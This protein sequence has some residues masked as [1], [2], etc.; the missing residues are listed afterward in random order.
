MSTPLTSASLSEALLLP[1]RAA[2]TGV[3]HPDVA[4][5][6]RTIAREGWRVTSIIRP[7]SANHASGRALDVAPLLFHRAGFG[8]RTGELLLRVLSQDNPAAVWLALAEDDHVHLQLLDP[9][10]DHILGLQHR[11][12]P[13]LFFSVSPESLRTAP[14]G[15]VPLK[16]LSRQKAYTMIRYSLPEGPIGD[17][18][19]SF[20]SLSDPVHV[21]P[22]DEDETAEIGDYLSYVSDDFEEGDIGDDDDETGDYDGGDAAEEGGPRKRG[23]RKTQKVVR[24]RLTAR[25]AKTGGAAVSKALTAMKKKRPASAQHLAMAAA[26]RRASQ[27]R[28]VEYEHLERLSS[29]NSSL[30]VGARLRST[31]VIRFAAD[32]RS[33]PIVEPDI[34]PFTYAAGVWTLNPVIL[35]NTRL[36]L[37]NGT[38]FPYTG[39]KVVLASSTYNRAAGQQIAISRKLGSRTLTVNARLHPGVAPTATLLN[40][41]IVAGRPRY[42]APVI[43]ADGTDTAS[44]YLVSVTGLPDN[45]TPIARLLVPG[46]SETERF[47]ALL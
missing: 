32:V 37:P 8:P 9:A 35:L 24:A 26:A 5:A 27:T 28:W 33:V 23:R 46:D 44:Q 30:G 16:P 36:G 2:T 14:L 31:E 47:L 43:E 15:S 20:P 39:L 45:Y 41:G 21:V 22:S 25:A 4:R 1:P 38:L 34:L 18:D 11:G 29:I 40:G 7:G 6:A 13:Q 17:V 12:S 3:I 19:P 42:H 10:S